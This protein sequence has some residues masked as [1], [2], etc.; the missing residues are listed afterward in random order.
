MYVCMYACMYVYV[1]LSTVSFLS[2][3]EAHTHTN[4]AAE[5]KLLLTP[6]SRFSLGLARFKIRMGVE[7]HATPAQIPEF[8]SPHDP[9]PME[10]PNSEGSNNKTDLRPQLSCMKT[11]PSIKAAHPLTNLQIHPFCGTNSRNRSLKALS[12][13]K[14][15]LRRCLL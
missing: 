15:L 6:E 11:D 10:A 2:S 14:L 4:S 8:L 13:H 1:Y 9:E 5:E 12:Y 3:Y 7:R